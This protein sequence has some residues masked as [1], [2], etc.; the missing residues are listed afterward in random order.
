MN[1]AKRC[2]SFFCGAGVGAIADFQP[3][4]VGCAAYPWPRFATTGI[5]VRLRS[6]FGTSALSH[7]CPFL[8]IFPGRVNFL[9]GNL[10][11]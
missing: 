5:I 4:L 8:V 3:A 1:A 7:R 11:F 10:E 9:T 2:I 6:H